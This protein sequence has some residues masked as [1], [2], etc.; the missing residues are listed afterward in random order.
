MNSS[1]V[2]QKSKITWETH[3]VKLESL[4]YRYYQEPCGFVS[5]RIGAILNRKLKLHFVHW[6]SLSNFFLLRDYATFSD[7][8]NTNIFV[9]ASFNMNVLFKQHCN[10]S[11]VQQMELLY[12]IV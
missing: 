8:F 11:C 12:L 2:D 6:K 10:L 4:A 7:L 9:F 1:K 3:Y 5:Y